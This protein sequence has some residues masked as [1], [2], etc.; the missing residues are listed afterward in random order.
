MKD[1]IIKACLK[2]G[3]VSADQIK[4]V[5]ATVEHETKGTYK[6][7]KE[8]FWLSEK[9]RKKNLRYYPYYGRG[10][11][12]ITWKK[13]Y[14]KFSKL[15]GIDMISNPDLALEFDN[16][17]FILVYG[18]KHG[19]FTGKKLDDYIKDGSVNFKKARK[20]INGNDKAI[21][22]AK[23]ASGIE[24]LLTPSSYNS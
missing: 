24:V 23:I 5:L 10:F 8:A 15:L 4:Y 18:M 21:K 3:V 7:V 6:P 12:Q 22:I 9:W 17:I 13:N 19:T 16:A 1:K 11:V 2:Q 20:I 14:K